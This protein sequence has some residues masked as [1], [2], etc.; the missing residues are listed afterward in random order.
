MLFRLTLISQRARP[1][2]IIETTH[3][4]R[5]IVAAHQVSASPSV[6]C[7]IAVHTQLAIAR[8]RTR[9]SSRRGSKRVPIRFLT[10]SFFWD[11]HSFK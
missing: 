11:F 7:R 8:K 5:Q 6:S 2:K 3:A 10:S 9:E 4:H 1:R